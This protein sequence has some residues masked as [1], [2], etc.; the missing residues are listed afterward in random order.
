MSCS[1]SDPETFVHGA[2]L[3]LKVGT[4]DLDLMLAS[5]EYVS[6]G[7]SQGRVLGIG[8]DDVAQLV[9]SQ[10]E[11]DPADVAPIYGAGAHD[12]RL[13]A[14]VQRATLQKLRVEAPGRHAHHLG[15]GVAGAVAPRHDGVLALDHD[16]AVG[17]DQECAEG[18]VTVLARLPGELDGPTQI[19]IVGRHPVHSN[20]RVERALGESRENADA[21]S[22]DRIALGEAA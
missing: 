21:A 22:C 15:L 8:A 3:L 2:C 13:R 4:A 17:V 19:S 14:R 9:L 11:H 10:G 12:A 7:Q 18:V 1:G 5:S 6:T 16:V 20:T